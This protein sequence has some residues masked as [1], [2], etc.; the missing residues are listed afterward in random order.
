ML[1]ITPGAIFVFSEVYWKVSRHTN[2]DCQNNT[3]N[4]S[5]LNYTT[6]LKIID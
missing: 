3:V 2:G 1:T 5:L 4:P 6:D